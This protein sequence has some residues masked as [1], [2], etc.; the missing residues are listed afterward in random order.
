MHLIMG[1]WN[2]SVGF[3]PSGGAFYLSIGTIGTI[4]T[5]GI[6]LM[7]LVFHWWNASRYGDLKY[8]C[9]LQ[10]EWGLEFFRWL[11]AGWGCILLVRWYDWYRWNRIY[12]I[13]IPVVK[14]ILLWGLR[15]FPSASIQW[16]LCCYLHVASQNL[17]LL[18]CAY[19]F[20]RLIL[21]VQN[22]F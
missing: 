14:C 7:L 4:G 5:N 16:I 2:I 15:I 19:D 13:G 8:F 1:A 18:S 10:A 3:R 20:F 12:V 9:W 6:T 21:V 22:M 11:Q 17:T